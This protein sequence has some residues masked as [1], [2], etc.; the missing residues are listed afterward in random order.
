MLIIWYYVSIITIKL[1]ALYFF[2]TGESLQF[3]NIRDVISHAFQ[4]F[5]FPP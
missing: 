4:L 5:T 2:I 3:S 1:L